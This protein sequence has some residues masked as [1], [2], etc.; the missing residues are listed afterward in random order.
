[1]P[2]NILCHKT[3]HGKMSPFN[4]KLAFVIT[5][6][7][8][9]KVISPPLETHLHMRCQHFKIDTDKLGTFSFEKPRTLS[10]LDCAKAKC[11]MAYD[12]ID[13]LAKSSLCFVSSEGSFGPHPGLGMLN[14]NKELLYFWD[15][16]EGFEFAIEDTSLNTN[17]NQGVFNHLDEFLKVAHSW[18]FPS[19]SVIVWPHGSKNPSHLFKGINQLDTLENVFE[20]AKKASVD[21]RVCMQTDM[22]ADQ[23]PTRMAFIG[24]L[25]KKMAQR[26]AQHCPKCQKP[27]WG[28]MKVHGRLP[29]K[30]CFSDTSLPAYETLTCKSCGF[31]SSRSRS[32]GLTHADPSYCY[33]CN[34]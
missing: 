14:C 1:M 17:L 22:R 5:K 9:Q 16:K 4:Q 11:Q 26:L 28:S 23:N 31:T 21:Q 20:I 19:H 8:K 30:D 6:H 15:P 13:H 18:L 25:A 29:C 2:K 27:G 10:A 34:P 32:D 33:S 3:R 12:S 24:E 7:G